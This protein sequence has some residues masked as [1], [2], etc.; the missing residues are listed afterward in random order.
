MIENYFIKK[1][2]IINKIIITQ[3]KFITKNFHNISIHIHK[4]KLYYL[5]LW[6]N[7][8]LLFNIFKKKNIF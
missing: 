7:I 1:I 3:N 8:F 2:L 6:K 5:I 4:F